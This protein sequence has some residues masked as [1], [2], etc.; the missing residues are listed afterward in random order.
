MPCNLAL[1]IAKAT[2][3][4]EHLWTL[5]EP[6][7][8]S[9][10]TSFLSKECPQS[11]VQSWQEK[12]TSLFKL[13]RVTFSVQRGEV[14]AQIPRSS[15]EA[16]QQ[17]AETISSQLSLLLEEAASR[18]FQNQVGQALG[19]LGKVARKDQQIRDEGGTIR[20]AAIFTVEVSRQL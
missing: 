5:L 20:Q 3:S 6:R 4:D 11:A 10:V 19:Q 18:L 17:L 12:A 16:E 7:L 9:L 15:S 13:D 8:Q 2:V 1:S 14:S